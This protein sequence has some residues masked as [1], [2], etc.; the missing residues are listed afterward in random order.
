[1]Q[2]TISTRFNVGD[3]V[4]VAD[5]YYDFYPEKTPYVV[6]DILIRADNKRTHIVYEIEQDELLRRVSE[7]WVFS[8]YEEC[9]KWCDEHNKLS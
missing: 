8:T 7:D 5:D 3:I 4:Y 2:L 6:V 9:T 1:M